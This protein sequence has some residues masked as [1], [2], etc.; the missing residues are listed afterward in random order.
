MKIN[1][2]FWSYLTQLF[3]ELEMLQTK[4]VGKIKAQ[5]CFQRLPRP[6]NFCRLCRDLE[7]YFRAEQATDDST[8][9][10]HFVLDT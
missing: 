6:E 3:F 1:I 4:V 8:A 10:A 5:I 2:H 7:K 9:H